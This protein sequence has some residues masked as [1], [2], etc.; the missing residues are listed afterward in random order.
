MNGI[1]HIQ[2]GSSGTAL[3][4][5]PHPGA[6]AG[7]PGLRRRLVPAAVLI[8]LMPAGDARAWTEGW[9]P[10]PAENAAPVALRPA[11]LPE[12]ALAVTDG[13]RIAGRPMIPRL[14][15][16]PLQRPEPMYLAALP[17][18]TV[19]QIAPPVLRGLPVPEQREAA[20]DPPPAPGT[21]PSPPPV[22]EIAGRDL[23]LALQEQLTRLKCNP[24]RVD[25]DWGNGSKKALKRYADA[26][27]SQEAGAGPSLALL[28]EMEARAGTMRC[29]DIEQVTVSPGPRSGK[30]ST[31]KGRTPAPQGETPPLKSGTSEI[32][33]QPGI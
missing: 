22:P 33:I 25:G 19:P 27:N 23:V 28:R 21:G 30:N 9:T 6:L 3:P 2:P 18:T 1:R 14:P 32:F 26:T 24:G 13:T 15:R 11:D 31:N 16:L 5:R 10:K 4:R 8:A 12:L 7:A 29:P 17:P 20:P